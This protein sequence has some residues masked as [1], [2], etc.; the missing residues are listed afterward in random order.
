MIDSECCCLR[1]T[2]TGRPQFVSYACCGPETVC[3]PIASPLQ[4]CVQPPTPHQR[5]QPSAP[6]PA[7]AA[8]GASDQT[9]AC[10]QPTPPQLPVC[11]GFAAFAL[12]VSSGTDDGTT[13]H[14]SQ[15]RKDTTRL[16]R[17]RRIAARQPAGPA[18]GKSP[19]SGGTPLRRRHRQHLLGSPP[20]VSRKSAA[21][22]KGSAERVTVAR[23]PIPRA[24]H[25]PRERNGSL[26]ISCH[27]GQRTEGASG[28]SPGA[29]HTRP[30][31]SG[32]L[33]T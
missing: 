7:E 6:S 2:T 27:A 8:D 10:L 13:L 18:A 33:A 20:G 11:S 31:L 19:G 21:A 22:F 26:Y 28:P 24:P 16:Q 14:D 3:S 12:P 30:C 29:N 17:R 9:K 25:R 23:A 32:R 4:F 1:M 5:K 15:W